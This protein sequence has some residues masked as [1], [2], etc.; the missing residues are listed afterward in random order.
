MPDNAKT[1]IL[2]ESGTNEL[3]VL[4]FSLANQHFGVNVAKVREVILPVIVSA[5]PEQPPHV[6]GVFDLRGRVLPLI[7]LHHYLNLPPHDPDENNRRIIVTEFNGQN[8]AFLVETVDRIHRMS[9]SDMKPVPETS[10]H[11]QSPVTG[12]TELRD[13]LL[14]ML[15]FES[16]VDHVAIQKTMHVNKVD[17]PLG[18]DRP[19]KRVLLAEDSPF[20]GKL[21]LDI[22]HNSGYTQAILHRNGQAAW[23]ALQHAIDNED[24]LPELVVSDIEMPAMDGLA[25]TRSIKQHP[26]LQHTPVILFSSLITDD[27]R[28]KG[29]QVGADQQIAKPQLPQLVTLIDEHFNTPAPGSSTTAKAA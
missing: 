17:N 11:H 29:K 16:I 25:L 20:I 9:W 2:L 5:A 12:I 10:P 19:A 3:E 15:D 23:D 8:A 28:H 26:A 21:M 4:V 7:D 24:P 6:R 13:Q 18:I 22:L 1:D 27:T 14:L